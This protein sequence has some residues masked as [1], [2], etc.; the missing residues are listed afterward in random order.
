MIPENV[1]PFYEVASTFEILN[2]IRETQ[3]NQRNMMT[4]KIDADR[5]QATATNRVAWK[6][7]I[8]PKS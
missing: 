3:M 2:P 1:I 7:A 6:A 5:W 8:K 4:T